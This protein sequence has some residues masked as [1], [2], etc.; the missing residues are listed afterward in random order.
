[1]QEFWATEAAL[2]VVMLA[3]NLMS[4]F[5]QVMLKTT[6]QHTLA[7]LRYKLFAQ[8]GYISREGR[9][10]ILKLATAVRKRQ[11]ISGLWTQSKRFDLPVVFTPFSCISK[12]RE[13]G[14]M[15]NSGSTTGTRTIPLRWH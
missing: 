2:N 11:W 14:L 6:P 13:S 15:E 1:M 4:L 10:R 12:C 3:F 7:M 5:R 8:A 9:K